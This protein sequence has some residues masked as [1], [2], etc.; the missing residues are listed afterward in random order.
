MRYV[1][2]ALS[3]SGF[4]RGEHG[5]ITADSVPWLPVHLSFFALIADASLM[6]RAQAAAARIVQHETTNNQR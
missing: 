6:L 4:S 3:R 5:A 2:N 1:L